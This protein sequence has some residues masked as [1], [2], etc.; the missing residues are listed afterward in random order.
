M[1]DI[2]IELF[3]GAASCSNLPWSNILTKAFE[4]LGCQRQP[5]DQTQ[6]CQHYHEKNRQ[7]RDTSLALKRK[8]LSNCKLIVDLGNSLSE[9]K[10]GSTLSFV[11]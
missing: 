11:W 6:I 8:W 2:P 7:D 4:G 5:P 1:R 3:L 9:N 10:M